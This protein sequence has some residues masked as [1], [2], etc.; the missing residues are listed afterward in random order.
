MGLPRGRLPVGRRGGP[1]ARRDLVTARLY[2]CRISH[3]RMA[4]LRNVFTYRT[5]LWLVDLD[6]LPRPKLAHPRL[7]AGFHARDHL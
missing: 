6:Q 3:A 5:Y 7:L 2:E 1:G 4:P